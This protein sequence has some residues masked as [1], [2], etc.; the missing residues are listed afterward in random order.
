MNFHH[1]LITAGQ[2]RRILLRGE[3]EKTGRYLLRHVSSGEH[4]ISV[5]RSD[6]VVCDFIMPAK[7]SNIVV[8]HVEESENDV[9][10]C[11]VQLNTVPVAISCAFGSNSRVM[12]NSACRDMLNY[13]KMLT[14]VM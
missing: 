5:V 6:E 13:L 10:F 11:I 2:A 7:E 9:R 8:T 12:H 1:G 14:N 3:G 4:V